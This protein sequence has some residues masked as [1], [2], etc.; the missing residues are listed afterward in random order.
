MNYESKLILKRAISKATAQIRDDETND[1][2]DYYLTDNL[3]EQMT[4]AA[5]LVYDS[6]IDG[7]IYAEE[8]NS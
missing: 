4:E 1:D 7:Q 3:D 5:A 8:N 2:T 6:C